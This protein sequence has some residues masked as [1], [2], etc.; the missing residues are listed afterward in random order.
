MA[1]LYKRGNVY[2]T[3]YYRPGSRKPIR[4]S[5]ETC[6]ERQ[7]TK[8]L[9][10]LEGELAQGN[11][12]DLRVERIKF[13]HLLDLV[14]RDYRI[15]KKKSLIHAKSR[16]EG[17]SGKGGNI[18]PWFGDRRAIHITPADLSAYI[19]ARQKQD[20]T[21]GTINRELRLISRA[22]NLGWESYRIPGPTITL[23]D[24]DNTREGFFDRAS[25]SVICAHL[26]PY[27]V[28]VAQFAYLTAWRLG[29]IRKLEWRHI[30]FAA[31]EIRLDASMTKNRKPR[32]ILMTSELRGL[33]KSV[34]AG[35]THVFTYQRVKDGPFLPIGDH[36]KAWKSACEA[37]GLPGR[38]FHDFRRSG[39]RQFTRDGI[40]ESVAMKMT[41]HRTR[42]VF[43]RYN[44]V[45]GLDLEEA[46]R[47]TE[48][49]TKAGTVQRVT[50]R[51][52]NTRA[53]KKQ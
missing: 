5:L 14:L 51:K 7:A 29:E 52:L 11:Y 18:R 49:G 6:D 23:L 34:T 33:L 40:Q 30:D 22:F 19:E 3:K 12:L 37:A 43:D 45:S 20:A 24:E 25:L 35:Q 48:A 47:K 16:I 9:K 26:P 2:W 38:L 31:G 1:S 44:I 13:G 15:N 41:G 32:V 53:R 8:R 17:A 36:R 27:L 4:T 28:P 46:R 50:R 39:V 10:I 42:S 21:N